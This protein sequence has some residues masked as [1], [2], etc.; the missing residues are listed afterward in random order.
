M[1]FI[2]FSFIAHCSNFSFFRSWV[3]GSCFDVSNA[4]SSRQKTDELN[5]LQS[6]LVEVIAHRDHFI[7]YLYDRAL[8]TRLAVAN[9]HGCAPNLE[10]QSDVAVGD[11]LFAKR[12]LQDW[13][14]KLQFMPSGLSYELA[15]NAGTCSQ[16]INRPNTNPHFLCP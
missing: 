8:K 3:V 15:F 11:L 2:S 12:N 4:R 14:L 7:L 6:Y 5:V 1:P 10:E 13:E 16:P 9:R